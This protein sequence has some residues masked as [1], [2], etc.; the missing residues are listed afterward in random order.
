MYL[1][2]SSK[3]K[4]E[5]FLFLIDIIEQHFGAGKVHEVGRDLK[6]TMMT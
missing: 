5:T 6:G 4:I 1:S 2:R 3:H